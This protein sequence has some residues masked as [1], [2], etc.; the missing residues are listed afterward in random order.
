MAGEVVT[1][2]VSIHAPA[3]GATRCR[4]GGPGSRSCFNPRPRA[5]G[6]RGQSMFC[7]SP[8]MFQ[9]TPP[10]GGRRPSASG[11]ARPSR[12]QSTPPRGGRPPTGGQFD[13][14]DI[15]SIHAPARG[16]TSPSS[17]ATS[18]FSSFNPRPR[19]GGDT[20]P[21]WFATNARGFNPRPRA[22]GDFRRLDGN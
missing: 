12:F 6:D 19:A 5:G 18:W 15:V 7:P 22:G 11:R 4:H 9:S 16:A 20:G 1:F 8:P 10:R 13:T 2:R 3:R 17:L 14:D 21:Q